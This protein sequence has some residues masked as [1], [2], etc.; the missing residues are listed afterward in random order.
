MAGQPHE[1]KQELEYVTLLS[2]PTFLSLNNDTAMQEIDW[3]C[4]PALILYRQ[5]EASLGAEACTSKERGCR[6]MLFRFI[7]TR[8]SVH[9]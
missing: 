2:D 4:N 5:W 1:N 7:F 3:N 9:K 8:S 6:K